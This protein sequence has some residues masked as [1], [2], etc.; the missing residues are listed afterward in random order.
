MQVLTSHA[1]NATDDGS[2]SDPTKH[3]RG[4]NAISECV[5]DTDDSVM[6]CERYRG[7]SEASQE[8]YDKAARRSKTTSDQASKDHWSERQ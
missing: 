7:A 3:G 5:L 6:P 2:A 8:R 1:A 4:A